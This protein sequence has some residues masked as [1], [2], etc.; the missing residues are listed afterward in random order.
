M[1][2]HS[3][4]SRFRPG[5]I[6][7]LFLL[8]PL[9]FLICIGP[10]STQGFAAQVTLA[11]DANTDPGV[12]GYK[13]YYGKTSRTYG[14][15]VDVG[16]VTEFTLTG[17]EEGKNGYFAV[18]AYDANRNESAFST[19]LECFTLV[20]SQSAN[21]SI[22]PS[23]SVVVSRGMNQTFTITP[24]ANYKVSDVTV[25]GVS[26]GAVTS[27]TFSNVTAN[28]TI[29]ASFSAVSSTYTISAS[30]SSKGSI[31]PSGSVSVNSGASQTFTITPAANYKVSDVTVDGVSV[32]AV[33]SYTFSS[34]TANHTIAAS[35]S[36]VSSTYTIS[37]SA[38]SRGSIS[39]S[40]SVSVNSGASQTFTITPAANC[41]VSD[42]TVDGVSVGAATSYTFFSITANH[43]IA[44]SFS[45][46][47]STYTISAS[48]GSGGNISPSGSVS[49]NS[50]ASQTFTITPNTGYSVKDVLVDGVS[51]GAV[52][53]YVFQNIATSHSIAVSFSYGI[54]VSATS[55]AGGKISPSGSIS[56]K[57]G[58]NIT[59]SLTP[60]ADYLIR[61]VQ[62]DGVSIGKV[63]S[64]TFSSVTAGHSIS[65]IFGGS[66]LEYPDK[67][68]YSINAS[69]GT[70]GTISPSGSISV[71]QG[72]SQSFA[73]TANPGYQ[74]KDVL[75]DGKSVGAITCHTFSN[76]TTAH[77]IAASFEAI[78]SAF[79]ISAS[80]GPGGSI[81]PAGNVQV[82]KG[83]NQVFAIEPSKNYQVA[84][85]L[86]NGTSV[87]AVTSYTFSK[88]QANHSISAT[89]KR[90]RT[91]G[92]TRQFDAVSSCLLAGS[93]RL[94]SSGGWIEVTELP[95]RGS[96]TSCSY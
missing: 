53:Q 13:L 57:Q 84:S 44:A 71:S 8:L 87:G 31:S 19:E 68:I 11:W 64:Y 9:I 80:A 96:R 5:F 1:T 43:N 25:D 29:A 65:V 69:A 22:S 42:V 21:G 85:V 56:V 89:F 83:A 81:S 38:S 20:P 49:V 2:G 46:V 33:T 14:T 17:I 36:A 51:V 35:F 37:A 88:V 90:N 40:G 95:G 77:S 39:P 4:I 27:Y 54:F 67:D 3:S 45:A 7:C 66:F 60:N 16:K 73:I 91:R 82:Q 74:V 47:S 92:K 55:S 59:F 32:G 61:D 18:T 79:T 62:V 12:A 41:K 23:G 10:G 70:N 34:V 94:P 6:P 72:G 93:G 76:V 28:H 78:S 75:V 48:A 52:Y 50:G 58:S 24:A 63:N 15:P 30:A 26:V 86:V